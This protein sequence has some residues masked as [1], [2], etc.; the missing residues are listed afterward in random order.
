MAPYTTRRVLEESLQ[1][2]YLIRQ[3]SVS[4]DAYAKQFQLLTAFQ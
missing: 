4:T 3:D 1:F 2:S